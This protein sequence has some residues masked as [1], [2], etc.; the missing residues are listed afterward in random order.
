ML[1]CR[2][3]ECLN[4]K[5]IRVMRELKKEGIARIYQRLL[6]TCLSVP[7]M[8]QCQD[9]QCLISLIHV[10]KKKKKSCEI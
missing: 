8:L 7:L 1:E 6:T 4:A 2:Q 5:R 9:D 10:K 3:M